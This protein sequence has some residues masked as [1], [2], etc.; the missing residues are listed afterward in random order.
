MDDP[1][2]EIRDVV[3]GLTEPD[4][5]TEIAKNI[6]KFFT[7]DAIIQH[8][9]VELARGPNSRDHLIGLYKIFRMFTIDQKILFHSVMFNEDLTSCAIDLTEH[10]HLRNIPLVSSRDMKGRL[11]IILDIK[12]GDDGKYR[13][14]RQFDQPI[15][16]I[17]PMG[18][19]SQMLPGVGKLNQLIRESTTAWAGRIG[20]LF[21]SLGWFGA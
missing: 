6:E 10:F 2:K 5:A 3:R 21:L 14:S 8:P 17:T 16:D 20:N 4:A 13:I 11:L 9:V 18:F 7:K 15:S 19:V 1:V 12:K